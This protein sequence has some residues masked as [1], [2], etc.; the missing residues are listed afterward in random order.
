MEA[1]NKDTAVH[2]PTLE[3]CI[4]RYLDSKQSEWGPKAALHTRLLLKRLKVYAHQHN[5]L[6]IR[7]LT[8]DVLEDFKTYGLATLKKDTSKAT[9]VAKLRCFLREAYR[10]GW[11]VESLAEKVK[12]HP[13]VYDQKTPYSEEEVAAILEAAEK[14]NGAHHSYGANGK[15]FRLLL[16]LMLETGMRAGDAV[17][18]DPAR[19]VRSTHLW[20]YTFF[21][22]KRK[23]MQK[24]VAAEVYL[25]E[26]LKK[27]IEECEWMSES[28]PFAYL[29]LSQTSYMAIRVWQNMRRIG[30]QC[31]PK[32]ADCRP[33]R[34]R[35]TFAVRAL[36]RGIPLEDVSKLLGLQSVAVTEKY[37]APW[38][39]SRKLR[40][41]RLPFESLIDSKGR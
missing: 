20:V 5:K 39:A 9:S 23:K 32:I 41:E 36:L 4:E 40:L 30:G 8:V 1:E 22:Q 26:R 6:F 27:A 34:L 33:H 13:A 11:I 17:R 3:N 16:E 31:N 18:F 29:P 12:A 14:Y 19:C 2:G 25:T 37:Y 24:P 35:D 15:T 28:L 10:R 38:I 7:E 21:P